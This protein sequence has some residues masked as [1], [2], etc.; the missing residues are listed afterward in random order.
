MLPLLRSTGFFSVGIIMSS[1]FNST[2][3]TIISYPRDENHQ[4]T[5]HLS[6]L[7]TL[8][9]ALLSAPDMDAL[10]ETIPG[11]VCGIIGF[12]RCCLYLQDTNRPTLTVR[13]SAGYPE[14]LA[15]NPVT[16]GEGAVGR[17]AR[18]R[19]MLHFDSRQPVPEEE[20][21][22]PTYR[23]NKGYARSLGA[24]AFIAVPI[25]IRN[26][27]CL[28]VLVADNQRK[29]VPIREEQINLLQAY[30]L[31]AGLAL[32]N[33]LL[34]AQVRESAAKLRRLKD[35]T[36]NVLQ[37]IE[38]AILTT[39]ADGHIARCNPAAELLLHGTA[40]QMRN[41]PLEAAFA[42]LRLPPG[43]QENL[44]ALVRRVQETGEPVHRLKLTLHPQ[45]KPA[46]TLVVMA[47]RLPERPNAPRETGERA[48]VVLIF[49]D[50]TQE[51]HLENELEKMR[52][53]ADI[54]QLAAKMAHE[55]RNALSPIRGA[56]QLIRGELDSPTWPDII[57][58]EVDGLSRLTTE[59]LNFARPTPLAP[60]PIQL[61]SLLRAA[62]KSLA[63]FLKEHRVRL[64]WK[65]APVLPEILADEA[66]LRQVIRNIVM[67]AAQ[68]MP[69]S[70]VLKIR[71]RWDETRQMA[72]MEF[73][74]TGIGIAPE[75]QERIFQ[76]F[77]TTR[78]KGTGLGLSIVQK[79][80][81]NH[82]GQVEVES[83]QGQGTCFRV[84]LPLV[85]PSDA[86][87]MS[88]PKAPIIGPGSDE[89]FPD[90]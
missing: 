63:L 77:M 31:Q 64:D 17:V 76:P 83:V 29:P 33:A 86:E 54:G 78:P 68:F 35:T 71:T 58:E 24:N 21:R 18:S 47:S 40:R 50:V 69:D 28:A 1:N 57:I 89:R 51:T 42:P 38:A 73:C 80:V 56:A 85:P 2:P 34:A 15:R 81:D 66:Q 20:Q 46:L 74:D 45:E 87:G 52:R 10:L 82:G 90:N 53:L 32:E 14:S 30:T 12:D 13:A 6:D 49:E 36:D 4:T 61:N 55:V 41:A 39:H 11:Q 60:A 25:L 75:E 7:S 65:L 5:R 22:A 27:T 8:S 43:E 44:L 62:L 79:N 48:G 88:R 67:N 23:Q 70:G 37:S 3:L 19:Q 26:E 16:L 59:M 72:E 84:W 9:R